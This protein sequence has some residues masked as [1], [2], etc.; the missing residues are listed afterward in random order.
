[1][2]QITRN[3]T[4]G[5][6][7][8]SDSWSISATGSSAAP[9][10]LQPGDEFVFSYIE[11]EDVEKFKTFSYD[12]LGK[13]ENRFVETFYRISRDGQAYTNWLTLAPSIGNFPAVNSSDRLWIDIKFVRKGTST[14]GSI[15]IL[16]YILNGTLER[17]VVQG[18]QPISLTPDQS[19]F[20]L[21]P[22]F[23][24]KVFKITDI[25]VISS[26]EIDVDYTIKYRYSQDY[27]RSISNWEY[28]TK[29]NITTLRISPI[30]FFQIEYLIELK[31]GSAKIWDINLIGDF[32]NVSKDYFKT[33]LYGV[34][35]DCN[36]LKL[37][38]VGDPSTFPAQVSGDEDSPIPETMSVLPQLTEEDKTKLFEPYKVQVA[39]DL[40][41]KMSN[42]ANLIFGHEITYFL[43]DP[44]KKGIDYTFHEYQ[45]YNF[46]ANCNI[47]VSVEGN[48]FPENTGAINQ[49]D[50]SLFDSFEIHVPKKVFKEAFGADKRP[51]KEDFLWFCEINKMFTVE[52][53]HAYRQF[54]NNS[55]Y[56]KVM[57]KKYNQKSN[58]IG[59][60]QTMTDKV[61]ALTRNSTINE[62]FGLEN[63]QDKN[64]VANKEQFKPLTAEPIRLTVVAKIVKELIEN[65][66]IIISKTNYDL[67]S[68]P[69]GLTTSN[70]AVSYQ[71]M[72]NYFA[73]G[74]NVSF[75]CWFN[76]NN[77]TYNDNYNMFNYYDDTSQQGIDITINNDLAKVKWNDQNFGLT[78]SAGLDEET[79]YA[80]LVNVDQRQRTISQYIYKR[81]VTDEADAPSLGSTK[82]KKIYS[83]TQEL[84]PVEIK[85]ENINARVLSGDMKITNL[86]FFVDVTPEEQHNKILNQTII[87][88]DSKYLI[89]ADNANQRLTLPNYPLDPLDPDNIR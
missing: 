23:I 42:D 48:Q 66:E 53:S 37:G 47:K 4:E 38:L 13:T 19:T 81:N 14:V 89:F 87:R 63:I 34:R 83:N 85:I 17:N 74:T 29:E 88:D 84:E 67:S 54:N 65:A 1:M 57:L 46:V 86:R 55:I 64:A 71:N 78:L 69:F 77:Y 36:C 76:I 18:D 21:K 39:T 15:K 43:T 82:L 58:V 8:L 80:Y 24:Y 20:I 22:P 26:G 70:T 12:Y 79:W 72:K 9:Q 28:F 44:D 11:L 52:H 61:T 16:E 51:S 60:N 30:R 62:L 32:Q 73:K 49:F 40:L 3:P 50:L 59:I 35:E 41:N 7:Q 56:Y 2:Y 10:L 33:N 6:I 5:T 25:E 68:V 45:L 75:M 31:S 27:G